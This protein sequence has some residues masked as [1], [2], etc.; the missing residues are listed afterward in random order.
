VK[1]EL[2]EVILKRNIKLVATTPFILRFYFLCPTPVLLLT[3]PE[4]LWDTL[5]ILVTVLICL[6]CPGT[7]TH[8][9][10]KVFNNPIDRKRD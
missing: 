7:C 2:I 3:P 4:Q 10:P 8:T 5:A 1:E 6:Q 9:H